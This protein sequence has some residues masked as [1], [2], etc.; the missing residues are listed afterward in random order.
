MPIYEARREGLVPVSTTSF[1]AEGWRER[2]DVQRLLKEHISIL[3]DGLMVLAEEFS[4]WA[5]ST[6]R[7]DLL[8]LDPLA[9]LVV[10]EL[11][12]TTD[13]GHMEL[14]ALRYAA[15]VSAMTFEQAV[16][17][18]ARHRSPVS[19]DGDKARADILSFLNWDEPREEA[20]AADTRILLAAADFGKE[21]TTTVLWLRDRGIDIRCI[22]LRPHRMEDGRLLLDVHQLVPPP[23]ASDFQTRLG[24]KKAA[25]RKERSER[26]TLIARFLGQLAGRASARIDLH[27]NRKPDAPLGTFSASIGRN[28]FSL[29]YVVAADRSRVELFIQ[30][31]DGREQ[32]NRL[33]QSSAAIEADF[34]A[35]LS[36]QEKDGVKQCRVCYSLAGGYASPEAD[37]PRLQD[38][39]ID[40][41]IR[42][43]GAVRQRVLALP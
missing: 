23:E 40:A 1:E 19:P 7:I 33:R 15:M 2:G 16:E 38:E 31:P 34:G 41:M 12:R 4:D 27:R 30:R 22:R 26:E 17:T 6:R 14:Q 5:D 20:F 37:W 13:G 3:Q 29:N 32:L 28:G 25:E 24:E 39:M 43:E 11:K 18:L 21:L 8:C 35:P 10:V 9:N 42:L 36:W